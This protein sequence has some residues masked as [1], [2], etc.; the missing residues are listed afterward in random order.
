MSKYL[1]ETVKPRFTYKGKK[2]S[3][4][5]HIKDKVKKEHQSNLIF[6]YAKNAEIRQ[7]NEIDYIG[8][9]NVRYG[10][11]TNEHSRKDKL[12]A[13]YIDALNN[14]YTVSEHDFGGISHRL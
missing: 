7:V 9:T 14:N 11:R 13:I 6:S 8:E 12:S 1:P 4:I 10:S 2:L 3:S 5:F